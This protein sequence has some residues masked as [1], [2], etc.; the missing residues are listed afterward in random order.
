MKSLI[1]LIREII[2]LSGKSQEKFKKFHKPM[3]AATMHVLIK[4]KKLKIV[5]ELLYLLFLPVKVLDV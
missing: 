2:H 4:L 5:E 1:Q 3:I